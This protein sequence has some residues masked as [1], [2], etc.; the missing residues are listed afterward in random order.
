MNTKT[1]R[2]VTA[3]IAVILVFGFSQ[4]PRAEF[5]VERGFPKLSSALKKYFKA[6]INEWKTRMDNPQDI[7]CYSTGFSIMPVDPYPNA[8]IYDGGILN[9]GY[10]LV[11]CE[12]ARESEPRI[13]DNIRVKVLTPNILSGNTG[14]VHGYDRLII[15]LFTAPS[16]AADKDVPSSS[17]EIPADRD[18]KDDQQVNEVN[19]IEEED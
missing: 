12:P 15:E 1:Y 14:D 4:T 7:T 19:A 8:S 13:D 3:I 18:K 5:S 16:S 9:G 6:R 11:V 2:K 10:P 17:K